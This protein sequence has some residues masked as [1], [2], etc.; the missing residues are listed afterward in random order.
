MHLSSLLQNS[1]SAD[2]PAE[3][4]SSLHASQ[5]FTQTSDLKSKLSHLESY[6]PPLVPKMID[7]KSAWSIAK[8]TSK[9]LVLLLKCAA[10]IG[11]IYFALFTT[12]YTIPFF[13]TANEPALAREAK[14]VYLC[15]FIVLAFLTLLIGQ[16]LV[17]ML[18]S[19]FTGTS[20]TYKPEIL[21]L[22][23][24][25][26]VLVGLLLSAV[27]F[28]T[29]Y[30]LCKALAWR[31]VFA[32]AGRADLEEQATALVVCMGITLTVGILSLSRLAWGLVEQR[33]GAARHWCRG[34][35][36]SGREENQ[37]TPLKDLSG[38]GR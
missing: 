37:G 14:L 17:G 1:V 5:P 33:W 31:G 21:W 3:T 2:T 15:C 27:L 29:L 24:S 26:I 22:R 35:K 23:V 20:M 11:M 12:S 7:P 13:I 32:A 6:R 28:G 9:I 18:L 25:Y 10:W 30:P 19:L 38:S 4:I 36:K 8:T 16:Q 34:G